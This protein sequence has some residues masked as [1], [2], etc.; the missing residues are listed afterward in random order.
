MRKPVKF[1]VVGVL[2]SAMTLA[3]TGIRARMREERILSVKPGV[4][5]SEV[6]RLLGPGVPDVSLDLADV[7]PSGKDQY[8]YSGNPSL[9]YGRF[10]DSII[11][12][13]TGDVV[14]TTT[15]IGL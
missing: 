14:S 15:R 3:L 5:R 9:W 12:R 4:H 11:V 13:Y 2:A 7:K 10:E 6:E 8:S 1:L